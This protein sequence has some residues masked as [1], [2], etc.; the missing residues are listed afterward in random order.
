LSVTIGKGAWASLGAHLAEAHEADNSP[1]RAD[2]VIRGWL[3][4]MGPCYP[5]VAQN[6]A[7]ANLTATAKKLAFDEIPSRETVEDRW[8]IAFDEWRQL[9]RQ[10]AHAYGD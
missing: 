5:H 4:H 6:D 8:E 10:I 9:K 1:L 7:Y 2:Q 3:A